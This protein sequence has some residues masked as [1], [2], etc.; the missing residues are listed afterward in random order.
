[1]GALMKES[2]KVS[3]KGRIGAL[4]AVIAS[5]VL[6][7]FLA[8]AF[9]VVYYG[10]SGTYLLKNVLLS[11]E[12]AETLN[13]SP[14]IFER[15]EFSHWDASSKQWSMQEVNL[16]QYKTFYKLVQGDQSLESALP[17]VIDAFY[18]VHPSSL[19]LFVRTVANPHAL[20]KPFQIVQF[21]ERK[22]YF[23]V[24]LHVE[25]PDESTR[26]A[27]FYHP[28]IESQVKDLFTQTLR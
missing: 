3:T 1:M 5:G 18:R 2:L 17:E 14:I 20:I 16:S 4:L 21:A 9:M 26:W 28:D 22:D 24:E 11:P 19:T 25:T 8:A 10:P 13:D 12:M 7:A 23:R 27:Y 15:L 6:F